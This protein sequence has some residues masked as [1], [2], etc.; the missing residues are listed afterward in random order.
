MPRLQYI[1]SVAYKQ[2]QQLIFHI[3]G[4]YPMSLWFSKMTNQSG[5]KKYWPI[6]LLP[7]MSE[8]LERC[9]FQDVFNFLYLNNKISKLHAAYNR[10]NATEFQLW[11]IYTIVSNTLENCKIKTLNLFFFVISAR[12]L[13]RHGTNVQSQLNCH[14]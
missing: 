11:E 9:Y 14:R 6:S 7:C 12:P 10:G 13:T 1:I 2:I 8:G 5:C 3:N 4:N